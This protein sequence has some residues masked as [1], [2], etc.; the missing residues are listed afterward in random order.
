ME[1]YFGGAVPIV[2]KFS[3][4][5]TEQLELL[6]DLTLIVLMWRIG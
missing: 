5:K 1:L 3:R 4:C 2:K 6:W